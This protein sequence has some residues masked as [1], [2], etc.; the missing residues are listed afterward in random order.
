MAQATAEYIDDASKCELLC[1]ILMDWAW[2]HHLYV[3]HTVNIEWQGHTYTSSDASWNSG[4]ASPSIGANTSSTATS[5]QS[6]DV[7]DETVLS[8]AAMDA[9][10]HADRL[11][12]ALTNFSA[13]SAA[14]ERS[15]ICQRHVAAPQEG[16]TIEGYIERLNALARYGRWPGVFAQVL[17][18]G[19]EPK[20]GREMEFWE[21]SAAKFAKANT[22]GRPCEKALFTAESMSLVG[23]HGIHPDIAAWVM[24]RIMGAAQWLQGTI[25]RYK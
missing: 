8:R 7:E 22:T 18:G 15:A 12:K 13:S 21:R 2:H 17:K 3:C 20:L 9:L 4:Q 10:Q 5:S 23:L 25:V 19:A 24:Q 6:S 11:C 16:E 14:G 1:H